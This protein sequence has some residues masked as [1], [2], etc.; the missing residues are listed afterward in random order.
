[1]GTVDFRSPT[2]LG[3][4]LILKFFKRC[5]SE[6]LMSQVPK[7][8]REQI[9]REPLS[10][11]AYLISMQG[12]DMKE[13]ITCYANQIPFKSPA[14]HQFL[15]RQI[16]TL[17]QSKQLTMGVLTSTGARLEIIVRGSG[18]SPSLR[19]PVIWAALH[20]PIYQVC[21][22][23]GERLKEE[24]SHKWKKEPA[25]DI[26]VILVW[27]EQKICTT[28]T[29]GMLALMYFEKWPPPRAPMSLQYKL[30]GSQPPSSP[31]PG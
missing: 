6:E 12:A 30:S 5:I 2:N 11:S 16:K 25:K 27:S 26:T 4:L 13:Y 9:K 10:L 23:I 7:S 17:C 1:M 28:W 21:S 15:P 14:L 22:I 31:S 20:E 18:R 29:V 19:N 24:Q 8:L 3:Q